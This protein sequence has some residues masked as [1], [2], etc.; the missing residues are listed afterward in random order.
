MQAINISE[1]NKVVTWTPAHTASRLACKIFDNF[2]FVSY[3]VSKGGKIWK[4]GFEH[5]HYIGLPEN[6]LDYELIMTCRNPYTS[7][8]AGFDGAG[9]Q[10]NLIKSLEE[11]YQSDYHINFYNFL[12][13]RKPDYFIRVENLLEDY[14]KVPFI[15]YSEFYK[16]G[17]MEKLI[18]NNPFKNKVY[19]NRPVIDKKL[20]DLIYYNNSYY[21]ELLGYDKNSWKK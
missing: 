3:N 1:K 9:A 13:Y 14:L 8:T 5:N 2:D 10:E 7:C 6:H 16:S 20:A 19:T 21:F 15:R 17:E 4:K 18:N 11:T 12:K